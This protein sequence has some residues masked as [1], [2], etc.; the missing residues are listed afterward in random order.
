MSSPN[1]VYLEGYIQRAEVRQV[2]KNG[3]EVLSFTLAVPNR[4]EDAGYSYFD[5]DHWNTPEAIADKIIEAGDSE[6]GNS[7]KFGIRG[8]LVQERWETE[9][10]DKRSKVKIKATVIF[11]PFYSENND[12]DEKPSGR[13][14]KKKKAKKKSGSKSG[15]KSKKRGSRGSSGRG[16]K[17]KRR[18]EPEDD[19][20]ED[21]D[22]D[23]DDG[24]DDVPF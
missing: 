14:S 20:Y 21:P 5:V 9:D 17:S 12:E 13:S 18:D 22:D 3:N 6:D 15:S 19:D 1:F 11:P 2:G 24:D 8:G 16:K 10:G 7:R 4:G 23:D